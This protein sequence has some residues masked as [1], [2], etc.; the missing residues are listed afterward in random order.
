MIIDLL[1]EKEKKNK[2]GKEN[3]YKGGK[4]GNGKINQIMFNFKPD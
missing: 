3:D 1:N 2:K 4:S